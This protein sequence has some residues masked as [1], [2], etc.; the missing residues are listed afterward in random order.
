MT[1]STAVKDYWS[2]KKFNAN[3]YLYWLNATDEGMYLVLSLIPLLDLLLAKL[4]AAPFLAVLV[5]LHAR[6]C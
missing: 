2:L 5:S 1:V 3:E 4:P 6:A